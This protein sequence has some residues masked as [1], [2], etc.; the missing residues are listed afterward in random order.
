MRQPCTNNDLQKNDGSHENGIF[1][2]LPAVLCEIAHFCSCAHVWNGTKTWR[3]RWGIYLLAK[4]KYLKSAILKLLQVD[5]VLVWQGGITLQGNCLN[6]LCDRQTVCCSGRLHK[7]CFE[8]VCYLSR[9]ARRRTATSSTWTW[10]ISH[11]RSCLLVSMKS[12]SQYTPGTKPDR[13]VSRRG[14][15]VQKHPDRLSCSLCINIIILLTGRPRLCV[16]GVSEEVQASRGCDRRRYHLQS[17]NRRRAHNHCSAVIFR[18]GPQ[19]SN[20]QRGRKTEDVEQLLMLPML[21]D[22]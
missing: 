20:F 16:K 19:H 7:Y 15:D 9:C 22:Y 18:H 11:P 8:Q 6:C 5:P 13:S 12:S 21:S 14:R 10:S 2:P 3:G 17:V 1:S 4:N